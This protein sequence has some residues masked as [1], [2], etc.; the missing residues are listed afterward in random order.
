MRVTFEG[1]G[2][3]EAAREIAGVR[4]KTHFNP[5]LAALNFA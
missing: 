2:S 4:L 5:L 1:S 3:V